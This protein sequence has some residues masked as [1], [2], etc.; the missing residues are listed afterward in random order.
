MPGPEGKLM[1]VIPIVVIATLI[2]SLIESLLVLPAHLSHIKSDRVDSIPLLGTLQEKFSLGLETF[3]ER[4]YRPFL[5]TIL[6]WRYSTLVG[7][8]SVF[9]M[10][11]GLMASGWLKIDFFSTIEA[12]VASANITFSPNATPEVVRTGIDR[13]ENA[14]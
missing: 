10:V 5:E 2:F 3:V 11:L 14:V 8:I 9:L 13:V 4:V 6:I 12:D 7:F 1:M